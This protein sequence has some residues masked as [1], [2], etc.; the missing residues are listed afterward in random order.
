MLVVAIVGYAA[1]AGP[2]GGGG[3]DDDA[4]RAASTTAPADQAD[5][6]TTAPAGTTAPGASE[7]TDP[8]PSSTLVPQDVDTDRPPIDLTKPPVATDPVELAR[9]WAGT[10]TMYIG[11]EPPVDLVAR[12]SD[13]T[14]PGLLDQLRALP[15]A[16]SYDAPLEIDGVSE[17]DLPAGTG[18]PAGSRQVRVSVQ[19]SVA[20]VIYDMTLVP[21]GGGGG[22]LVSEA[23]RL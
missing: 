12:L 20:L 15:P 11:A 21:G 14:A 9:W 17:V 22:W 19:A 23:A 7:V 10:Y 16:A 8:A 4:A 6:A 13:W 5:S 18:A 1:L 3:S 2:G